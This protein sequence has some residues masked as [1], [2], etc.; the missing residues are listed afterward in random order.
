LLPFAGVYFRESGLFKGLQAKEIRKS[1]RCSGSHGGLW[2]QRFKQ[3]RLLSRPPPSGKRIPFN[4]NT[5]TNISVFVKT[6]AIGG[7]VDGRDESGHD[8]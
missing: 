8:G 4:K 3:P 6:I 5:I 2:A 7:R 1:L